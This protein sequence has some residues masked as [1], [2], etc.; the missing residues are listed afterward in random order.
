MDIKEKINDI[1]EKTDID[2]K[3]AEK[4][5]EIKENP[6]VIKEKIQETV[7]EVKEKVGDVIGGLKK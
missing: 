1:L 6:A 2:E 5:E 7:E 4:V 3:I